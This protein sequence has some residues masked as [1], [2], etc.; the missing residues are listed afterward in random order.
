MRKILASTVYFFFLL[1]LVTKTNDCIAQQT[2]QKELTVIIYYD[3]ALRILDAI[4]SNNANYYRVINYKGGEI[5]GP[6]TDYYKSGKVMMSGYYSGATATKGNEN[7]KFIYYYENGKE[8]QTY[9]YIKGVLEGDYT[10]YYPSGLKKALVT[11]SNGSRHG[12]EYAW[13]ENGKLTHHAFIQ[14]DQVNPNIECDTSFIASADTVKKIEIEASPDMEPGIP[15]AIVV[16]TPLKSKDCEKRNTGDYCFTN[17]TSK[18]LILTLFIKKENTGIYINTDR[19]NVVAVSWTTEEM[20]N[21]GETKCFADL[22]TGNIEYRARDARSFNES[23][24]QTGGDITVEKCKS[25][26]QVIK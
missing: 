10:E 19:F 22:A 24:I 17:S 6:I 2:T 7:G 16:A 13:D 5:D 11:Y 9:T 21:A 8:F 25:N 4:D 12:C 26:T 1:V 20:V 15:T 14:N 18:N 3:S 23:T